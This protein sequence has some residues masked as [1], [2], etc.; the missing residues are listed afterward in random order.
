MFNNGSPSDSGVFP[1]IAAAAGTALIAGVLSVIAAMLDEEE[2]E[3]SSM[4]VIAMAANVISATLMDGR[5][6]RCGSNGNSDAIQ[7]KA[8][9]V[10]CWDHQRAK[11]CIDQYYLG[12]K[13]SFWPEDFKRMFRVSRRTYDNLRNYLCNVQ[14]FF[15]CGFDAAKREK[16]SMDAKILIAFKYLAYG[17]TVNAF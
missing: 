5:S 1:V 16:I 7:K 10:I 11:L 2:A 14:P 17:T 15:R 12:P 4:E 6:K 9:R 13:P 3:K 8:R